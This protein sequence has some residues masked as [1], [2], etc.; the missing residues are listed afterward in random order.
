M[1]LPRLDVALHPAGPAPR[2]AA[3]PPL[4]GPLSAEGRRSAR[5]RGIPLGFDPV[6][7]GWVALAGPEDPAAAPDRGEADPGEADPTG[8]ED[9]PASR[10][11]AA[12]TEARGEAA[13]LTF[14]PWEAADLPAFRA[15]LDDP[16]V[17][18]WLPEPYPGPLDAALAADLIA[19]AQVETHHAV[20]AVLR[21]G[22]PVGQ[23]RL[24]WD[25]PAGPPGDPGAPPA[26]AE[27]SY[28]LGR[29][30][31]GQGIGRA[32]LAAAVPAAFAHHP[33]LAR[34]WARVHPANRAS[35]RLLEGA[36]FARETSPRPGSL[37]G[38]LPDGW[39]AF[40][41]LRD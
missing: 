9:R 25:P 6:L 38:S 16:E 15:L 17:W 32:M 13:G 20:R 1:H 28:W 37:P 10:P 19:M 7:Q 12:R 8:A 21:Q 11:A 39:L 3:P 36:G 22:R 40:C 41:R 31:W 26:S 30:H 33:R 4:P 14:R 29:D 5:A 35:A 34:L 23:V 18:R 24:V 2:R 27:I